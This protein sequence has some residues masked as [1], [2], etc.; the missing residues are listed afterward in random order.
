M[1]SLSALCKHISPAGGMIFRLY[2]NSTPAAP[3]QQSSAFLSY[4]VST[5]YPTFSTLLLTS[6][7]GPPAKLASVLPPP[8]PPLSAP[9]SDRSLATCQRTIAPLAS[10]LASGIR[11]TCH[12]QGTESR[13]AS[14]AKMIFSSVTMIRNTIM[15]IL[16][17]GAGRVQMRVQLG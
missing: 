13:Q 5:T 14:K 11:V 8:P 12:D 1:C 6:Q 15:S 17:V 3:R 9:Y 4:K 16:L 2:A 7:S 10:T